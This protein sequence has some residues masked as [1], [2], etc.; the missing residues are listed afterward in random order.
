MTAGNA[1]RHNGI[2]K[3][4]LLDGNTRM[5]TVD[6][7]LSVEEEVINGTIGVKLENDYGIERKS[8]EIEDGTKNKTKICF[9]IN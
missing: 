7:D 2:V 5:I 6:F 4:I 1:A 9:P 8:F 3:T